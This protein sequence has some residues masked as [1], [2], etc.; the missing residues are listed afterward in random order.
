MA[1]FLIPLIWIAIIF[2]I[3]A[4]IIRAIRFSRLP[5]HL[6]WELYP[7]PHEGNRAKYGGSFFEDV[8]WWVKKPDHNILGD[9]KVMI[10]EILFL[11]GVWEHNRSLWFS[12]F[13]FHFG[14]YLVGISTI[15][16]LLT[17][18]G[19][20]FGLITHGSLLR[21]LHAIY[22]V[23]GVIGSCLIILGSAGLLVRR[24]KDETLRSYSS[25]ADF[26]NLL[27]FLVALGLI[28]V[29]WLIAPK[30]FQG[31]LSIAIA[32]FRFDT[33]I[34]I[35][36]MLGIGITLCALLLIY[37]PLTHMSHFIAK[38]FTYHSV[39]WEDDPNLLGGRIEKEV[40]EILQ[41]KPTWSASHIKADGK[42]TWVDIALSNP[43][44]K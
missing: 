13:P 6:R 22:L 32:L 34:E 12:S 40:N 38:Y 16:V 17:A 11:K 10:P 37:I 44:D 42:K 36:T 35:P 33:K 1:G 30:S 21:F 5:I 26:F 3:I 28:I 15:L 39:R 8:D 18:L 2:F 19:I 7:V 31:P 24:L 29:G 20:I 25:S 43:H 14:I 41:E 9:L 4:S 27:F 23:T